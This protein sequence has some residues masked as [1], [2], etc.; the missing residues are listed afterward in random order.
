MGP[1]RM[2]ANNELETTWREAVVIYFQVLYQHLRGLMRNITKNI[3][4]NTQCRVLD[5]KRSPAKYNSAMLLS[6]ISTVY[7]EGDQLKTELRRKA[8]TK[9]LYFSTQYV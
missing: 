8:R 6:K 5:S 7:M 2:T 1:R 3:S 4:H 9:A